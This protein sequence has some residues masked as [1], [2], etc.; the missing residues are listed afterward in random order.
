MSP[1]G[2]PLR[3]DG[4]LSLRE[5]EPMMTPLLCRNKY[6]KD[7]AVTALGSPWCDKH[8]LRI[9]AAQKRAGSY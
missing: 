4:A 3:F 2:L 8:T 6:C 5:K 1:N 7:L 9:V